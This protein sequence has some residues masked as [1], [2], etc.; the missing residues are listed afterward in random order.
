M[1]KNRHMAFIGHRHVLPLR[2]VNFLPAA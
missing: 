1:K 2:G